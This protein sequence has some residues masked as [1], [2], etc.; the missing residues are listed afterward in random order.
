MSKKQNFAQLASVLMTATLVSKILGAAFKIPLATFLGGEGMGYYMTAYSVFGP[1]SAVALSGMTAALSKITA[2]YSEDKTACRKLLNKSIVLYGFIGFIVSAAIY[3][4]ADKIAAHCS[5]N[6]AVLAVKCIAPAFLFCALSAAVRGYFEGMRNMYPTAASEVVESIVKLVCGSFLAYMGAKLAII[7]SGFLQKLFQSQDLNGAGTMALTA[8]AAVLGVTISTFAGFIISTG[9]LIK[10]KY[11]P[12]KNTCEIPLSLV[13]KT[14]FPICLGSLAANISSVIDLSTVAKRIS[15]AQTMDSEYFRRTF[16]F[17]GNDILGADKVGVYF[18]GAYTGM[19][20]TLFNIITTAAT[21]FQVSAIPVVS[22]SLKND[23]MNKTAEKTENIIKYCFVLALPLGLGLYCHGET[24]LKLIFPGKLNEIAVI[25]DSLKI[26]GLG[27]GIVAVLIA[28]NG[29]IQAMGD[30]WFV[31]STMA[32][33]SLLKYCLNFILIGIPEINI[34]GAALSAVISY[35]FALV[36]A[37][38]KLKKKFKS[39]LSLAT[40]LIKPL[41]CGLVFCFSNILLKKFFIL[42][43]NDFVSAVL[44]SLISGIFYI[45]CI[46]SLKIVTK[47]E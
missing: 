17:L 12:C 22:S 10:D 43:L 24:A 1:V 14:A 18:F 23:C 31:L 29:I 39:N 19:A 11:V 45:F 2:E 5:D 20:M 35:S 32:F 40:A 38:I 26:L 4:E 41:M 44:S 27:G 33:T 9:F 47:K 28:A 13:L 42:R 34:N 3:I 46:F 8:A 21:V 6:Y 7:N 16:G 30:G 36:C 37:L 25:K 15:F